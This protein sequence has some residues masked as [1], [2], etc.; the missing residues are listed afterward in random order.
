[1]VLVSYHKNVLKYYFIIINIEVMRCI[2]LKLIKMSHDMPQTSPISHKPYVE[3]K[4]PTGLQQVPVT[5]IYAVGRNYVAHAKELGN[6]VPTEPVIFMK[7]TTALVHEP[8]AIQIPPQAGE[9][10]FETE[11]V[12]LIGEISHDI[13][14]QNALNSVSGY[15]L[16]LDLTDRDKQ[17][18]LKQKGLP[19]TLAKG[20]KGSAPISQFMLAAPINHVNQ[21]SFTL[22]QNDHIKQQADPMLMI[23]TL[24]S[25]L[26]FL[27]KHIGLQPGDLIFTGTPAGVGPIHPGDTLKLTFD[28][29][30][31]QATFHVAI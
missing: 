20:F 13:D 21:L 9:I 1:M 8:E 26:C 31:L 28:H 7:P 16:G 25:I 10:H 22:T 15:G 17:S 30:P 24:P 19:W 12:L 29:Y 2:L 3:L 4:T 11:L 23:F 5:N 27:H 6:D 18:D 14:L